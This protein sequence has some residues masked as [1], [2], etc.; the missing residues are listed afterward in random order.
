MLYFLKVQG[1]QSSAERI[2][3]EANSDTR[4]DKDAFNNG[5][6][7]HKYK[8]PLQDDTEELTKP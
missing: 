2:Y 1:N 3:G 4:Y 5:A 6:A 7:Y 8:T